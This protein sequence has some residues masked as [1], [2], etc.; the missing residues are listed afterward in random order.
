M[1]DILYSGDD[2]GTV[3]HF[4]RRYVRIPTYIL[5]DFGLLPVIKPELYLP[6]SGT[7]PTAL[8]SSMYSQR[9]VGTYR[10]KILPV[11]KVDDPEALF[12]DVNK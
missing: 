8:P 12:L 2:L 3:S 9:N 10:T 11:T 1:D 4:L 5:F 6:R 7:V